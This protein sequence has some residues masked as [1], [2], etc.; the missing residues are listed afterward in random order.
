MIRNIAFSCAVLACLSGCGAIKRNQLQSE[1]ADIKTKQEAVNTEYRAQLEADKRL[2]TI[3]GKVDFIRDGGQVDLAPVVS[4]LTN[5][6]YPTQQDRDAILEWATLR[7]AYLRKIAAINYVPASANGL[8]IADFNKVHSM[9][10]EAAVGV[11]RMIAALSQGLMTYHE[12]G[13]RRYEVGKQFMDAIRDYQRAAALANAQAQQQ[14]EQEAQQR[15]QT[16]L[17]AWGTYMQAVQARQPQITTTNCTTMGRGV[18]CTQV[19]Q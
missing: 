10:A 8:Q 19:S 18:N 5:D 3:R 4:I 17:A 13:E 7:D 14:A 1:M 16:T 9:Q 2:D 11:S 6:T 12:F 15:F